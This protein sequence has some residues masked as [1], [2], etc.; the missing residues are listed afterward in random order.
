MGSLHP[1]K[2]TLAK[3]NDNSCR[4]YQIIPSSLLMPLDI[5][6]ELVV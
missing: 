3:N 2:K 5:K 6:F 1:K 4:D